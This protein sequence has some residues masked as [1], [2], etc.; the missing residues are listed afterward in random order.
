MG[1]RKIYFILTMLL[2]PASTIVQA[3]QPRIDSLSAQTLTRSGRLRIFGA[4][5]GGS[6][7]GSQVLI[8]FDAAHL[9]TGVYFYRLVANEVVLTKRMLLLRQTNCLRR[10]IVK[11][12]K[13]QA[14]CYYF[15]TYCRNV[16]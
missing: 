14:V 11:I 6:I 12:T 5:F 8:T 3:Q 7:G 1:S 10:L 4:N 16:L 9:A 15:T 13:W 2:V